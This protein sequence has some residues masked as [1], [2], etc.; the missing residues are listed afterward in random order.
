MLD[1][2][3]RCSAVEEFAEG[4][5]KLLNIVEVQSGSRF[6]ENVK[7]AGIRGVNEMSGELQPLGLT[8]GKRGGRLTQAEISQTYLIEDFEFGDH[9]RHA[10][11]EV[12]GLAHGEAKDFVDVFIAIPHF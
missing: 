6:V 12:Q 9:A 10:G 4:R 8:S 11:E 3:E 1:D 5:Q 7:N 2:H